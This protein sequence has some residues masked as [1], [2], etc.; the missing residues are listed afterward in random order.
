MYRGPTFRPFAARNRRTVAAILVTFALFS[1]LSVTL[2]IRATTRSKNRASVVEVAARQRTLAE[3]YVDQVLLARED[4][5]VDPASTAVILMESAQALLNGGVAPPVNGDDDET[6]LPPATDPLVRAQLEQ[7]RRLVDDLTATGA[8]LLAHWPLTR[9]PLTAD[10]SIKITDPVS[11]VRVLAALT[12]N[13]SLNAARTFATAADRNVGRLI[14][15]QIVLGIAGFLLSVLLGWALIAATRRQTAHFRTLVTSSTDLVLIF[16]T[17]GCRYVGKSVTDALGREEADLLGEG[18]ERFVHPDDRS[19]MQA[20]LTYG[21]THELLVR[22][23]NRFG[24]WRHLEAHVT[25]LRADRRVRGVV[26]N[27]R[28]VTERVRLEEELTTQAF[29][30]SL[31]GLANRALFRDRLEQA[32]A[33]SGRSRDTLAVLLADLDGFKQI[34]DSLGHDAGDRLLEEVAGRFADVTRPSDTV[35]KTLEE[36]GVPPAALGLEVTETAIVVEGPAGDRARMELEEL[37]RIGVKI[38]IDD[39]GTGFSSLN[40]LR[41]FPIDVLKVDR[42]FIQ[43]V[44]HDP[45]DAAITANL[46]SLAHALGLLAIAEGIESDGQRSSALELGCDLA[47]G[48]LFAR[49]APAEEISELL[50]SDT[51]SGIS[52]PSTARV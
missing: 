7:E 20:A 5:R 2:A 1:T 45:K 41:S 18:F 36:T 25:D 29:H 51:R 49:P 42:S 4:P 17:G 3:R 24:E 32:L 52:E 19:A 16:G 33:R 50:A 26:L 8:A 34:N 11:R 40:Q 27:A 47:Q 22:M 44:E 9:V 28:D 43:G 39:F 10:E 23:A 37:H 48:Y 12:S 38:A 6:R 30:D 21:E 46:A 15:I 35:K 13:V 31:T 14:T